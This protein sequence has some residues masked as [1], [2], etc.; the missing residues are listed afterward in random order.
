MEDIKHMN[1]PEKG[2][3]H[4]EHGISFI[5]DPEKYVDIGLSLSTLNY[6]QTGSIIDQSELKIW[7]H[8]DASVCKERYL[9]YQ[10]WQHPD[11]FSQNNSTIRRSTKMLSV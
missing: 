3:E 4:I 6:E 8:V 11:Q 2:S 10:D 1:D 7:T 5:L 9:V